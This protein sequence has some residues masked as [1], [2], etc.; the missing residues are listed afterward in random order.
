[1]E[2]LV[3]RCDVP[4]DS[5]SLSSF[6]VFC[7]ASFFSLMGTIFSGASDGGVYDPAWNVRSGED[8]AVTDSWGQYGDALGV[9]ADSGSGLLV[10][11]APSGGSSRVRRRCFPTFASFD[12]NF[13]AR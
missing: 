7:F 3:L 6:L 2:A 5:N 8:S 11:L 10:R 13:D 4:I 9:R 1:M 12:Q